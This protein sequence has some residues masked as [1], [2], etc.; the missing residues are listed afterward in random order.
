[1]G[2][3]GFSAAGGV[4]RIYGQ[5][6]PA[7]TFEGDNFVLD[8][9]VV[10][11]ATKAY[12]RA[13]IDTQASLSPSTAYLRLL[14][15]APPIFAEDKDWFDDKRLATLLEMRAARVVEARARSGDDA[16]D[17]GAA[18]RVSNAVAAAF[19][20]TQVAGMIDTLGASALGTQE[21]S[22]M[23]RLCILVSAAS[24]CYFSSYTQL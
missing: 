9:Q 2:G 3:H 1:M 22:A 17:P 23:A 13:Q 19:V 11:S 14:K 12:S 21:Q 4:G 8:H 5:Y 24:T 18:E 20:G 10:R 15:S 16:T 7:V 6:L